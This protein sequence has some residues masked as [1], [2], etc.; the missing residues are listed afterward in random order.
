[1]PSALYF[2]L[3]KSIELTKY[4]NKASPYELNILLVLC[5]MAFEHNE[6]IKV[7]QNIVTLCRPRSMFAQWSN[8]G[9]NV[10]S[11][12]NLFIWAPMQCM[13][14]I[15]MHNKLFSPMAGKPR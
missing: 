1:M 12:L 7:C 6:D 3:F 8:I 4:F 14:Q 15:I 13:K 5:T 2:R 9:T 11:S 10:Q